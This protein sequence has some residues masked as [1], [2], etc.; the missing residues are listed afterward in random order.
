MQKKE[1]ETKAPTRAEKREAA[2]KV[3]REILQS[4][5]RKNNDLIDEAAK[6]FSERFGGEEN[7]NANDVKGRIGSVLD[8]MK[9]DGEVRYEGGMCGLNAP[10]AAAETPVETA[11]EKPKTKRKT[12]KKAAAEEANAT[13]EAVEEKPKAKRTR[14]TA[15]AKADEEKTE[16]AQKVADEQPAEEPVEK[17]APKKRAK[18][19]KATEEAP[20]PVV[21]EKKEEAPAEEKTEAKEAKEE[22]AEAKEEASPK[23]TLMDMSFLFGDIKPSRKEEA[24]PTKEVEEKAP[25]KPEQKP[26]Q[27]P[28]QK[29]EVKP[30]QKSE[31]KPVQK[32]VEKKEAAKVSGRSGS[33]KKP[34]RQRTADEKLQEAFLARLHKLGGEYFEYYSIYLLERYSRM[35]GRRLESLQVTAGDHDGGID[36]EIELTD[37]LG[38]RETIYIQAKNWDPSKGDEKLWVVGETLL[39]Q[40]I[41]ACVCRQAK[42]GKQHCRGIFIT[43]SR[44]T[45]EAKRIL[46]ETADKFVGYDGAD[47]YETAKECG[48]GI[49]KKNGEWALDEDLLSGTKAFFH[50]F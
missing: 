14:K 26:E 27:K 47:L 33:A 31:Q 36:G 35:N 42:D 28:V 37:R 18:K 30:E 40:F 3:I 21:E 20:A 43:T 48:F 25:Q 5:D 29:Q 46:D 7:E 17:P 45:P 10:V 8:I 2:K 41:G 1:T 16:T 44:F 12:T 6:I 13:E 32:I 38:F 19:A 49:I 50:M 22:K 34:A 9:K 15:K 4:A 23:G 39:Q 11:E 24:K